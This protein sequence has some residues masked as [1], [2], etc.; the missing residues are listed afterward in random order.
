VTALAALALDLRRYEPWSVHGLRLAAGRLSALAAGGAR[1]DPTLL[2]RGRA[3]LLPAGACIV[4]GVLAAAGARHVRVSDHGVRH[5]Y[6][7]ERLAA[8]GVRASMDSLWG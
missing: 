1:A 8:I 4:E 2:D 7:R 3:V 5:A 6:L